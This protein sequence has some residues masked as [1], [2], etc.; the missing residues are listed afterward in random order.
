MI[1]QTA[2]DFQLWFGFRRLNFITTKD[3]DVK[4]VRADH[5]PTPVVRIENSS[6]HFQDLQAKMKTNKLRF[7]QV[8][9]WANKYSIFKVAC[10]I[11]WIHSIWIFIVAAF[12][13]TRRFYMCTATDLVQ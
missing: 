12:D 10:R 5:E 11:L 9:S 3:T 7:N 4:N 2:V 13:T 8:K 1:F 6:L